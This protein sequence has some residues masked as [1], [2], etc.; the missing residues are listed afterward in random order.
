MSMLATIVKCK[1]YYEAGYEKVVV[2]KKRESTSK[3]EKGD[4]IS[5]LR[6]QVD[7]AHS[8]S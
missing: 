8:F 4:Y 3:K 6:Q 7:V 2:K 5:R 1:D